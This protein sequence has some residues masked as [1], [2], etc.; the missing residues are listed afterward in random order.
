M[1]DATE[2]T[3]DVQADLDDVLAG[4]ES[5]LEHLKCAET[6]EGSRDLR[7]CLEDAVAA[8]DRATKEARE[9]MRRA[10]AIASREVSP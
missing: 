1:S 10:D 7:S 5:A 9:L 8:L 6:C 4:V 3:D 2:T